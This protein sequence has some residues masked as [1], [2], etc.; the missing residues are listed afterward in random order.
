M[1][2]ES[3]LTFGDVF[4]LIL[5]LWTTKAPTLLMVFD[6]FKIYIFFMYDNINEDNHMFKLNELC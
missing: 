1:K 5:F 2:S 4:K 3:T 6:K